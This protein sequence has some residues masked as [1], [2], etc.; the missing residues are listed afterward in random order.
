MIVGD[1][2]TSTEGNIYKVLSISTK[3]KEGVLVKFIECEKEIYSK[4]LGTVYAVSGKLLKEK[5]SRQTI[6]KYKIV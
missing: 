2:Y 1:L 6:T 5:Y 4:Y 3:P